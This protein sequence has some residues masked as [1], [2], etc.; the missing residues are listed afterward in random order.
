MSSKRKNKTESHG[1]D[2]LENPEALATQISKSEEFVR[3]HRTLVTI[4]GAIIVLVVVGT[5]GYRFYL[6]NQNQEAQSEMYQAIYYYEQDSLTLALRGDGNNLGFTDIVDQYGHT[7]AGN[8]ANF[9][10]GSIYLKQ[11]KYELALLFLEDF[12]TDDLLYQARAASLLGDLYMEQS[13]FENAI[14][15]YREAIDYKPNKYFTPTYLLKAALAYEKM[16][17]PESAIKAYK[18]IVE[19]YWDSEEYQLAR[20]HLARLGGSES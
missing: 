18:E 9:Y 1:S 13:N 12:S 19:K 5:V 17:D 15:H 7:K 8:L 10:A 3:T 6:N 16:N 14:K 4:I 20:K 2:L 11:G